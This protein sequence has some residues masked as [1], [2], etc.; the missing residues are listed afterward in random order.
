MQRHAEV[1]TFCCE[2]TEFPDNVHV[3]TEFLRN[4]RSLEI[5]WNTRL[6]NSMIR[7][8]ELLYPGLRSL[9]VCIHSRYIKQLW[10]MDKPSDSDLEATTVAK[11][12]SS[13]RGLYKLSIIDV[14]DLLMSLTGDWYSP[15]KRQAIQAR[16]RRLESI[17]QKM[18]TRPKVEEECDKVNVAVR[19]TIG[20]YPLT[21]N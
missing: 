7:S 14:P 21:R 9:E 6:R 8:P 1:N 13:L 20:A 18:V 2:H 5:Y 17:I 3:S 12:L 11:S 15:E 16:V 10:F 19:H 4:V